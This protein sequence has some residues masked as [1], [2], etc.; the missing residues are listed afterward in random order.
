[1]KTFYLC[2]SCDVETVLTVAPIIAAKTYGAPENCHPEEGGEVDPSE[3]PNC[4]HAIDTGEV[5]TKAC[6]EDRDE[7]EADA[8]A[9][10]ERLSE[11]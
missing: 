11:L 5:Y 3:C 7:R 4:G 10:W 8:E 1:M 6:E 9:K 2:P